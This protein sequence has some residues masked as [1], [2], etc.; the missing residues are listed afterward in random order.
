MTYKEFIAEIIASRG[1]W[2][3]YILEHG[4]K[5]HIIPVC[6]GGES[7]YTKIKNGKVKGYFKP[8]S[9]HFNCIYLTYYEH[10]EAHR[11]LALENF[12]NRDLINAFNAMAYLKHGGEKLKLTAEQYA[13]AREIT[14]KFNLDR[15]FSDEV[16]KKKG[17]SGEANAF[18]GHKHTDATKNI[19]SEKKKGTNNPMYGRK[20]TA[21]AIEAIR[22]NG[23]KNKGRKYSDEINK[24]KSLPGELNGRAKKI[25]CLETK[26]IFN[27]MKYADEKYNFTK[28]TVSMLAKSG[29]P[30]KNGKHWR[31]IEKI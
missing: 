9:K 3:D 7:D 11:L 8:F 12:D 24:K 20:Q 27:C 10:Y 2:A 26:E 30:D 25:M 1:Q 6:I 16:N 4:E 28:G 21:K 23:H 13:E 17:R 19:Q 14:S 29:A 31:L 18:Y 15:K 22:E 5:H